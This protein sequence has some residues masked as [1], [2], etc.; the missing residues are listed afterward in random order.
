MNKKITDEE[1]QV[2]RDAVMNTK[3]FKQTEQPNI[4]INTAKKAEISEKKIT[5]C[6]QIKSH[7]II[8]EK[9]PEITGTDIISFARSGVQHKRF[10]QLKQGK[11]RTEATLDLH[12]HTSDEA[13]NAVEHFLKRCQNNGFRS[14]CI[15]HGKGLY[16]SDNK[17]VLKNLLN[18][19]LRQHPIVLAF[20]S[21]K[22]NPGAMMVLLKSK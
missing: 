21:E 19:F 1:R 5:Q 15:I 8:N 17:P 11:M 13:I 16:T 10:S 2:F 9:Q 4:K 3:P 12:E 22:N 7:F 14:V 6:T 18:S 20:H